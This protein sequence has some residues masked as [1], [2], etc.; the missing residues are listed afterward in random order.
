MSIFKIKFYFYLLPRL[1]ISIIIEQIIILQQII[2]NY[3]QV[4]VTKKR[5]M[6]KLMSILLLELN[7][8]SSD[9]IMDGRVVFTVNLFIH[10]IKIS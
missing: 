4:F 9:K 2:T 10:F 6:H 1:Y 3:N 8:M 5:K 7:Q